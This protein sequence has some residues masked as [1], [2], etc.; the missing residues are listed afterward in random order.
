MG[1]DSLHLQQRLPEDSLAHLF[2]LDPR[3]LESSD[4]TPWS[5]FGTTLDS[6]PFLTTSLTTKSYLSV[7]F[8]VRSSSPGGQ[9]FQI[10]EHLMNVT[11]KVPEKSPFQ[12]EILN[13]LSDQHHHLY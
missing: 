8:L 11:E 2:F 1:V 3:A 6:R 4:C 9:A 5:A 7:I 13:T 12:E 10:G